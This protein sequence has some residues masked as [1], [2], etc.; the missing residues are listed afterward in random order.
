MKRIV[1]VSIIVFALLASIMGAASAQKPYNHSI[2]VTVGNY[3]AV[4]YKLF[5]VDHFGIQR[6]LGTKYAY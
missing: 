6:D 4:T 5:P 2:G 1:K 3:Q